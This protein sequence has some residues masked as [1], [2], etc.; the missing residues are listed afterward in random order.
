MCQ[1]FPKCFRLVIIPAAAKHYWRRN[2]SCLTLKCNVFV[3]VWRVFIYIYG[4]RLK[5]F[6]RSNIFCYLACHISGQCVFSIFFI[7]VF[8]SSLLQKYNINPN[9]IHHDLFAQ[10][11]PSRKIFNF[12]GHA[13]LGQKTLKIVSANMFKHYTIYKVIFLFYIL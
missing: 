10:T 7:L 8:M 5:I 11:I 3:L 1:R 2:T 9:L 13:E 4:S 6:L 12:L